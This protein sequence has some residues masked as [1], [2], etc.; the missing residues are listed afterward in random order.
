MPESTRT[1]RVTGRDVGSGRGIL[2]TIADDRIAA[3][4]PSELELTSGPY[5]A[6]GLIDLQVNGFGGLDFNDG[7]LTPERVSALIGRTR[8]PLMLPFPFGEETV[9]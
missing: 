8:Y 4:Q 1:M 2:V 7:T 5:L 6:A 9:S 3:I